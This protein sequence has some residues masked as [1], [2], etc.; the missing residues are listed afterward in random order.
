MSGQSE[1]PAET[2]SGMPNVAMESMASGD[3]ISVMGEMRDTVKRIRN[4]TD[5]SEEH[6]TSIFTVEEQAK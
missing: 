6:V 3:M 5:V 4:S 1:G 2:E